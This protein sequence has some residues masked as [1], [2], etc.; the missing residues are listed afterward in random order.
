MSNIEAGMRFK[1]FKGGTYVVICVGTHSESNE[2]VVVY[3][4]ESDGS[5]FVRPENMFLSEVDHEKYPDVK[6]K[7]RFEAIGS[8][9]A[10]NPEIIVTFPHSDRFDNA[11]KPYYN[12]KWY[13]L[14]DRQWCIGFSSYDL[15]NVKTWLET[16]F[17]VIDIDA[18]V[19][20][21]KQGKWIIKNPGE[22]FICSECEMKPDG[23]LISDYCPNCGAKMDLK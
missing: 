5:I 21:V 22:H 6:Q 18:E 11:D 4:R 13:D 10:I 1:H 14:S 17:D 8:I 7:N 3:Q 16:E 20:P 15:N 9:K 2:S 23:G 19:K 12:I